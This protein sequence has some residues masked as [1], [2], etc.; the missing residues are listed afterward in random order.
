M[1]YFFLCASVSVPERLEIVVNK[2]AEHTHDKWS[3]DKVK[4]RVDV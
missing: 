3:L 4:S 1:Y 2:F